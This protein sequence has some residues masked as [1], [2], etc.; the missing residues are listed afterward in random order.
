MF[1]CTIETIGNNLNDVFSLSKN[2]SLRIKIQ[3]YNFFD[4]LDGKK[5]LNGMTKVRLITF[6]CKFIETWRDHL[7]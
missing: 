2:C 3:K 6:K 5:S 7:I 1:H 4:S